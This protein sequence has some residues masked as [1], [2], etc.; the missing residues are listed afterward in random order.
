MA[1]ESQR[2][3]NCMELWHRSLKYKHDGGMSHVIQTI[4]DLL[5]CVGVFATMLKEEF[6]PAI[7]Q[8]FE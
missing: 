2:Y 4:E 3:E 5:F 1:L 8:H 7:S 6:V